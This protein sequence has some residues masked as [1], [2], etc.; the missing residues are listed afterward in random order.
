MKKKSMKTLSVVSSL[1]FA[2]LSIH[3]V[4][5]KDN[6]DPDLIETI[7]CPSGDSNTCYY[8]TIQGG[9]TVPVYKGEGPTII[10][11]HEPL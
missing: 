2:F 4:K 11:I 1:L 7:E 9:I 10:T 5:A 6:D 3:M 8:A